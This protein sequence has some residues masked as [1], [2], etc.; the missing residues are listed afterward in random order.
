ML[1]AQS[2]EGED[3]LAAG[4]Q[5]VFVPE[6]V[7]ETRRSCQRIPGT[8]KMSAKCM[9]FRKFDVAAGSM[10]G[11]EGTKLGASHSANIALGALP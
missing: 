1:H 10:G 5:P 7:F 8:S 11:G 2:P 4:Q 6:R 3:S 9:I